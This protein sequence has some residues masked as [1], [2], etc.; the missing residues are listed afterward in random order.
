MR[1]SRQVSMLSRQP[2]RR[3]RPP[4][5]FP[6][7]HPALR[8]P[9]HWHHPTR[10]LTLPAAVNQVEVHPRYQ[11]REL[12]AFCAAHGIAVAAYAPLGTGELLRDPTVVG[13]AAAEGV[14]PAQALLLWGLQRGCAVIPKSVQRER[15]EQAAPARL[16]G[17]ALGEASLAALDG[18]EE[19]LGTQKYCWEPAGIV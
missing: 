11:Q 10:P 12:R 16:L 13:V 15:L 4:S 1:G 8:P 7:L 14:T 2:S 9:T 19:R 17:L 5:S 3:S 18:L 6:S